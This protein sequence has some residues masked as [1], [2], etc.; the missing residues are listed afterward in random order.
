MM[1]QALHGALEHFDGRQMCFES[2]K[3][4]EGLGAVCCAKWDLTPHT[5]AAGAGAVVLDGVAPF[6]ILLF[7]S[8]W[9]DE[10]A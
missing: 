1:L 5:A 7:L 2:L 10:P 4:Y 3:S 8:L 6:N 9:C